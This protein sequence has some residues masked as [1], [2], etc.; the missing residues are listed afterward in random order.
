MICV[1]TAHPT[2][3]GWYPDPEGPQNL[4]YW[5]GR[6]WTSRTA[7]AAGHPTT[8]ASQPAW[9]PANSAALSLAVRLLLAASGLISLLNAGVNIW[10]F[11]LLRDGLRDPL[12]IEM[13]P[14][15]RYDSLHTVGSLISTFLL[16]LTGV[17]WI[18]WQFGLASRAPDV[19]LRR[20]AGWHI[21]SWFV[22]VVS[23]WF[24]A[25]NLADL[26]G[27]LS[28]SR[29]P[30]RVPGG[31]L[32]WWVAWIASSS[33]GILG[34][35]LAGPQASLSTLA[36]ATAMLALSDLL[37]VLAAGLAILVVRDV[38]AK[39]RALRAAPPTALADG[40]VVEQG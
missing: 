18:V 9:A 4:R 37:D 15:E 27:S 31:Y 6:N 39:V 26:R 19:A 5:D 13:A 34:S 33:T 25:Q 23:L 29:S 21:A 24:P 36:D 20:S 14:F 2:P 28:G 22:P 40:A 7:P 35:R 10:G 3:A 17:I 32:A 38:N 11:G 16:V 8:P 30:S 12:S 1:T